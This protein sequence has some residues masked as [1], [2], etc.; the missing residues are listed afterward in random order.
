MTPDLKTVNLCRVEASASAMS[1]TCLTYAAPN[2]W[3]ARIGKLKTL[4][5]GFGMA[6]RL[7]DGVSMD[8]GTLAPD[9]LL[10]LPDDGLFVPVVPWH[11]PMHA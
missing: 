6:H 8:H 10:C 4:K 9:A 11:M 3:P 1:Y 7:V 5:S 2:G